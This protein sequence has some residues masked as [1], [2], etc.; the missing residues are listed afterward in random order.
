[1]ETNELASLF[2]LHSLER[3]GNRTLWK[4]KSSFGSFQNCLDASRQDLQASFLS[5][6]IVNRIMIARQNTDKQQMLQEYLGSGSRLSCIEDDD[7]PS[8]LGKTHDPPYILY[9]RGDLDS[10]NELCIAIVGS[11]RASTYGKTQSRR[12]GRELAGKGITVVSGMARGIDTEAHLGA[13]EAGGKTAAVLGSGLDVIYPPENKQLFNEISEHGVVLTELP[14]HTHP[15]PGNFPMRNRVIA[16]LSRGVLVV[17]AQQ[18]SGALITVDFALEQGR[19]VFAIPGQINNK[20]S[21]G[22]NNLIKQGACMVTEINDIL[23]E[24][25]LVNDED[26]ILQGELFNVSSE[27]KLIFD[28]LSTDSEHFD[29]LVYKSKLT[30]GELSTCL[31]QMELKGIIKA[32]PGNYYV[33]T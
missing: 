14:P 3:I 29:D 16:G 23:T 25:G 15:E 21:E 8:W 1:M 13:L 12:F 19:D 33:K 11:R 24:Y 20:N 5:E 26:N 2:C 9:Y 32:L 6:D 7:Y 30:I 18:R 31:L 10:L 28:L 27:E 4:I 17:E 22:T